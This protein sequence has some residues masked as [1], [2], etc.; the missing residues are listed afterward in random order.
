MQ[1]E[2]IYV[3]SHKVSCQGQDGGIGHPLVFLEI[4]ENEIVCPYC[5]K[6]YRL[7]TNETNK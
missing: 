7:K 6:K 4:K 3:D 1:E 5:S 2:I